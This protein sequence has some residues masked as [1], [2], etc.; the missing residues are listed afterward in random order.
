MPSLGPTTHAKRSVPSLAGRTRARHPGPRAPPRPSQQSPD[1]ND[2]PVR[3]DPE[4][5]LRSTHAA[6]FHGLPDHLERFVLGFAG[7]CNGHPLI[8]VFAAS[9]ARVC[10]GNAFSTL[11]RDLGQ[12]SLRRT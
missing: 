12:A 4:L 10:F 8:T 1:V 5:L 7:G 11:T 3:R 9:L 6:D 2:V